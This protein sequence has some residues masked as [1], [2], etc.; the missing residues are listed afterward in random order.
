[1]TLGSKIAI[2]LLALGAVAL[3]TGVATLI[4]GA[5]S[6]EPVPRADIDLNAVGEKLAAEVASESDLEAFAASL[7]AADLYEGEG[8]LRVS[9]AGDCSLLGW[10]DRDGSG[11]PDTRYTAA[12]AAEVRPEDTPD[13]LEVVFRVRA[14][15]EGKRLVLTDRYHNMVEHG[16]DSA[17]RDT[18][19]WTR[20]LACQTETRGRHWRAPIFWVFMP[21][22]YYGGWA[23]SRSASLGRRAGAG[24]VGAG[25]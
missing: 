19:F 10:V 2:V 16:V 20:T 22:G 7:N 15:T 6:P 13:S 24:G 5:Q 21:Y 14:E 4:M 11:S 18:P 1:M 23:S 8:E 12:E 17:F 25:K 9:A 3:T